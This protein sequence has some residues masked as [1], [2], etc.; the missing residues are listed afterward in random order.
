MQNFAAFAAYW[1][2]RAGWGPRAIRDKDNEKSKKKGAHSVM[3]LKMRTNSFLSCL[4][5][6]AGIGLVCTGFVP[7]AEAQSR[8]KRASSKPKLVST[9]GAWGA[10]VAAGSSK[11][12]YALA[13]PNKRE[14]RNLKRDPGFMF[15]TTQ[16]RQRVRNEISIIMGFDAKAGS[17]P[18]LRIGNQ[19]FDLVAKGSNLW[20]KNAAEE[21][22]L[23]AAMR[24]GATMTVHVTSGR[25]NQTVDTYSLS[26]VT[27][28]L[29]RVAQECK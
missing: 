29:A 27:Q 20:I 26:G 9:H 4:G 24:K 19:K 15:I 3:M 8:S 1:S 2:V 12:C 18:E 11:T 16:P 5:L 10:Y 14:P 6:L 23:I 17:S 13:K 7:S 22:S 21:G 25:G 28:A